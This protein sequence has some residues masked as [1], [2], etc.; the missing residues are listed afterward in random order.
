VIGAV[1]GTVEGGVGE[2]DVTADDCSEVVFG[3]R[4]VGGLIGCSC[5]CFEN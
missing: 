5:C 1:D 4:N 3:R 2:P